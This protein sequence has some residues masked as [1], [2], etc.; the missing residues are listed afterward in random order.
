MTRWFS[1]RSV[2]SRLEPMKPPTPVTSHTFG[3]DLSSAFRSSKRAI[4]RFPELVRRDHATGHRIACVHDALRPIGELLVVHC[5]V[6]CRN[7][8][9]VETGNDFLL[10]LDRL[11]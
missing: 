7:Q 6:R 11:C 2:S 4:S 3:A 5:L 10:P 1:L 8:Y 9:H